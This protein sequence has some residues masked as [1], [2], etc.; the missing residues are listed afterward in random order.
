MLAGFGPGLALDATVG[1][2]LDQFPHDGA[3]PFC[4]IICAA[5]RFLIVKTGRVDYIFST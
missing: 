5:G 1:D 3:L 2:S 4:P